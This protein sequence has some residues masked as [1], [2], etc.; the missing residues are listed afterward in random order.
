MAGDNNYN[1]FKVN[2]NMMTNNIKISHLFILMLFLFV[3]SA[4]E[5]SLMHNM[6]D[7]QV[8]VLEPGFHNEEMANWDNFTYDLFVIKSGMG[9]Q[10]ANLEVVIDES[11]LAEYNNAH[12][13]TYKLLPQEYY[14]IESKTL[15]MS[16]KEYRNS[17]KI[18][19]N[20]A[21]I[22]DL[23]KSDEQYVLPCSI[24]VLD[25]SIEIA[26]SAK[27]S[28]IIAPVI[29]EPYIGFSESGLSSLKCQIDPTSPDESEFF[30][31]IRVNY[32]NIWDLSFNLE[33]DPTLLDEYN[34]ENNTDYKILPE[35]AY[36]FD[37][38]T[39][40]ILPNANFQSIK[41]KILKKGFIDQN[42]QYLF[43]QYMIPLRISSVSKYGI[44]PEKSTLLIP[45]SF[46]PNPLNR[47]GWEVIEWNSCISEEPQYES[48]GRT[49]DWMLDGN[50]ETYWGSKW[51]APKPFP[52][53]FVF[54]MKKEYKVFQIGITKPTGGG[55]E[56]RGN[57]KSGY[58][59][60]SV[61]NKEWKKLSDWSMDGNDPRTHTFKVNA[62]VARYIR[63][64]VSEAFWYAGDGP[65]SGANCDIAEFYVWGE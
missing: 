45:V 62:I 9:Q 11:L 42:N 64:V 38:M 40:S 4:C 52:Y 43:G 13:T 15:L 7:D 6:V 23:Q 58:F 27:M 12:Q 50:T 29:T 51:D 19:F 57:I 55:D 53:Y 47:S 34:S 56:W 35:V 8:Y 30:S 28:T 37:K 16:K 24:K 14:R 1:H 54:D 20:T 44:N 21:S 61:D 18:I 63:F 26:D 36:S 60:T 5:D 39:G 41:F 2:T 33:V 22:K 59:E 46:N 3:G 17:F 31:E 49:P 10:E 32:Q 48:L 25:S 65:D